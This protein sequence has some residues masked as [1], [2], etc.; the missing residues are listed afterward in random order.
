MR[1]TTAF[2][3]Q[4]Y[5]IFGDHG[6]QRDRDYTVVP[7]GRGEFRLDAMAQDKANNGRYPQS[8]LLASGTA[9]GLAELRD[10]TALI[11]P[12]QAVTAFAMRPWAETHRDMVVRYIAAYIECLDWSLAPSHHDRC[13]SILEEELLLP[14][15]V[16]DESVEL[17]RQ[18]SFGLEP[19]AAIDLAGLRNT[20]ALRAIFDGTTGTADPQSYLDLSYHAA[21]MR[22]VR[23]PG[24]AQGVQ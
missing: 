12:Y 14:H 23:A 7:V 9:P 24:T 6:L 22:L 5:K 8:A 11:G 18:P 15:D 3:L 17:L 1:P 4:A 13:V 19:D 20:L 2:A 21:A 10:T 16:A